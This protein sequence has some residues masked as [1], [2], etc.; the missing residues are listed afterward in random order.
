MSNDEEGHEMPGS[1]FI[2]IDQAIE[3]EIESLTDLKSRIDAEIT[4]SDLAEL[5][6]GD[7]EAMLEGL[8]DEQAALRKVLEERGRFEGYDRVQGDRVEESSPM[9]VVE[10]AGED[11]VTKG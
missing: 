10:V 4:E 5:T 3:D 2:E 1:A 9:G 11:I 8:E 7:R 6:D